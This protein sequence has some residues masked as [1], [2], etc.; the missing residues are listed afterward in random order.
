VTATTATPMPNRLAAARGLHIVGIDPSLTGTGVAVIHPDGNLFTDTFTTKLRGHQRL[1]H[2]VTEI[3]DAAISNVRW[4][5]AQLVVIEGPS[6]GN[7]G[8]GRQSGHH[9]RAGLWWLITHELYQ[10][11]VPYAVVPPAS[12]CRYATGKGNAAK[13]Q[14]LAA[15]LKRFGQ[16]VDIDN[17]N[18]ADALVLAAMAAEH[19]GLPLAPMPATHSEA[20]AKVVWPEVAW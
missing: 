20:L 6:Y 8:S 12:R 4:G 16:L 7:Q 13:D 19:R 17:N 5:P 18:E 2:I 11:G 15:V 9:E 10:A 14:V 1:A 3:R